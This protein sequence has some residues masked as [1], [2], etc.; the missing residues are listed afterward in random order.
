[1][2]P[3]SLSTGR[4]QTGFLGKAKMRDANGPA[5]WVLPA[6]PPLLCSLLQCSAVLEPEQ[7]L[8]P[9]LALPTVR[10]EVLGLN[11]G[12]ASDLP[13]PTVTQTQSAP[14]TLPTHPSDPDPAS[15]RYLPTPHSDRGPASALHAAHPCSDPYPGS[16]PHPAQAPETCPLPTLTEAQPVPYT[17]P[18]PAPTR[19]QI[20]HLNVKCTKL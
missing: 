20:R 12:S 5:P 19:T 15:A 2:Q 18:T 17:L 7:T 10:G 8:N 3:E 16:P 9:S 14:P 6:P 11:D 13:T 4:G 1:M